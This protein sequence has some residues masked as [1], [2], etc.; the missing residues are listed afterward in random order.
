MALDDNLCA[1]NRTLTYYKRPSVHIS[2]SKVVFFFLF[3][4]NCCA[5]VWCRASFPPHTLR[6]LS[7]YVIWKFLVFFSCAAVEENR[8]VRVVDVI[9]FLKCVGWCA[10]SAG[11]FADMNYIIKYE[12]VW[13]GK[14]F[15]CLALLVV[16][17][18]ESKARAPMARWIWTKGKKTT[19]CLSSDHSLNQNMYIYTNEKRKEPAKWNRES[20]GATEKVHDK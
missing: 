2:F 10:V 6:E 16:N 13:Y 19:R 12:R 8:L 17:R 4:Q 14:R 7:F 18:T 15:G 5:I 20:E 1:Q 3:S 11:A 9:R